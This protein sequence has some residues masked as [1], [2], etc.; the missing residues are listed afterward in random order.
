MY[1]FNLNQNHYEIIEGIGDFSEDNS[2]LTSDHIEGFIKLVSTYSDHRIQ[3][4]LLLQNSTSI[5]L[6]D[7][8]TK[9]IQ[10]LYSGESDSGHWIYVYY[11]KN[12]INYNILIIKF[13]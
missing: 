10:L 6:I 3:S 13:F 5:Q 4:S 1:Q 2:R 12:N 7:M 8:N 9:S 11:K